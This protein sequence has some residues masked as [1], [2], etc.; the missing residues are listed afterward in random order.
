MTTDSTSVLSFYF[1][2]QFLYTLKV[3]TQ[4]SFYR[5]HAVS[6]T[7]RV[8]FSQLLRTVLARYAIF[9]FFLVIS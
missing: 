3:K 2:G 7:G 8:Y 9:E 4:Q 5:R 6:C 1:V